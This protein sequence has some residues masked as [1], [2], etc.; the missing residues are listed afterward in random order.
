MVKWTGHPS[1]EGARR[2]S[3]SAVSFPQLISQHILACGNTLALLHNILASTVRTSASL[4]RTASERAGNNLKD[5]RLK[6]AQAKAR[7]WPW[8]SYV[9][10]IRSAADQAHVL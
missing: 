3:Q 1:T 8:R 7:F 10:H 4:P 2:Q 9:C 6:M 5:F